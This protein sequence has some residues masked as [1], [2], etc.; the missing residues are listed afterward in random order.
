[1]SSD[2]SITLTVPQQSKLGVYHCE[3]TRSGFIAVAGEPRDIAD[4]ESIVFQR[5]GIT[6]KRAG[7][8]YTFSR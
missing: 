5:S 7:D 3:V 6:A 1:M 2:N 8:Q 4:G